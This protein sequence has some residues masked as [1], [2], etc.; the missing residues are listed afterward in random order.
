MWT[1]CIEPWTVSID[2][3]ASV[4]GLVSS[5]QLNNNLNTFLTMTIWCCGHE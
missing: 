4:G 3:E 5:R 2:S 1:W